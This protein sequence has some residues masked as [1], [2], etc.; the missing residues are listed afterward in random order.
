MGNLTKNISRWEIE[1]HCKCGKDTIDHQVVK[2]VQEAADHFANKYTK[3]VIVD[4][5]SGFRC[6]EKNK[7]EGGSEI[8]GD[9]G[10]Q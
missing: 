8:D 9:R 4:I 1:C 5:S 3:K 2:W 10:R 6:E 7:I